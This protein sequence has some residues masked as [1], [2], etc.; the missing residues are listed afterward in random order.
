MR[1]HP[2]LLV[3]GLSLWACDGTNGPSTGTLQVSTYTEG[4]EPDLDGYL[5]TVDDADTLTLD[6]SGLTDVDLAVGH[7][8]LRL[9]GVAAHCA[10]TS[11]ATLEVEI[12]PMGRT[13]AAFEVACP[14]ST[15]TLVVST[16]TQ[17]DDPDEDGFRLAID[18]VDAGALQP[19]GV[20]EVE[21]IPGPH[22]VHLLGV[23]AQ[24]TVAAGTARQVD[25]ARGT[26]TAVT[27]EVRC[28]GTGVRV[29]VT[30][31]GLDVDGDGYRLVVDGSDLV[32]LTS[33]DTVFTRLVPGGRVVALTGLAPNCAIARSASRA[34][35]ITDSEV[36]QVVFTVVCTAAHGIIAV[37]VSGA[38]SVIASVDGGRLISVASGLPKYLEASPGKHVVS[39]E[40]ASNC[41]VEPGSRSVTVTGGE[42]TRD[43]VEVS[44]AVTCVTGVRVVTRTT[45][46]IPQG[47][48]FIFLTPH[49]GY[50]DLPFS[51]Y[52]R[53]APNDTLLLQ[54]DPGR[55][56]ACLDTPRPCVSAQTPGIPIHV[57]RFVEI[58]FHVYCPE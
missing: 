43:T 57:A 36:V 26:A 23:A 51:A 19:T 37:F 35:T 53:M 49:L 9:L 31:T 38:G 25:V 11:D 34:V 40:A 48:Y 2:I 47:R 22:T 50:C 44:F 39:I 55:Y 8:T 32:D 42:L 28:P 4:N 16:F 30:T 20:V 54:V 1:T 58:E 17:G 18:D 3:L 13:L 14:R 56:L 46:A 27:F 12:Q 15:G 5:L 6:A 7:H 24:C 45:G 52:G 41:E 29:E 33:N 10:V 21:L